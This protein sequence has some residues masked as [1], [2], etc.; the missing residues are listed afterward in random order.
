MRRTRRVPQIGL[1]AAAPV[2]LAFAILSACDA[3]DPAGHLAAPT[4]SVTETTP[5]LES[6]TTGPQDTEARPG[7]EPTQTTNPTSSTELVRDT[8]DD[9]TPGANVEGDGRFEHPE[10]LA[11]IYPAGWSETGPLIATQFAVDAACGSVHIVDFEPPTDPNAAEAGFRLESVVQ[12]C[13]QP[14]D[15]RTLEEFLLA[16]YGG[17]ADFELVSLGGVPAYRTGDDAETTIFLEQSYTRYQVLTSVVADPKVERQ[18]RDE[19]EQIL[20]SVVFD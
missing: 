4:T 2:V 15:G 20:R 6:T 10:G 5:G 1:R 3:D 18:R 16:T 14:T 17:T 8:I 9:T 12:V 7:T 11:L 13:G 19:V